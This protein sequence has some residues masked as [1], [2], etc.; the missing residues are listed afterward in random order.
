MSAAG[1]VNTC[2]MGGGVG[3]GGGVSADR[4]W[5]SPGLSPSLLWRILAL[6]KKTKKHVPV[7]LAHMYVYCGVVGWRRE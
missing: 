5:G 2:V 6:K 4:S 7:I 3:G 1:A